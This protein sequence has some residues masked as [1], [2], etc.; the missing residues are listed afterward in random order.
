VNSGGAIALAGLLAA[1][2]AA[3]LFAARWRLRTGSGGRTHRISTTTLIVV[4]LALLVGAH[5]VGAHALGWT[6]AFP[7]IGVV[8]FLLAIAGISLFLDSR[9]EP[10]EESDER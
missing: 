3:V 10:D 6:P 1:A 4:S 2:G 9:Q 8:L 5:Q 7:I